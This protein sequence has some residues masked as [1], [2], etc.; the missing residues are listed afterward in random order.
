MKTKDLKTVDSIRFP[1]PVPRDV[2]V[3]PECG[4]ELEVECDCWDT[5]TGK[6]LEECI[7]PTCSNEIMEHRCW[8][9]EW[10][11]ARM[12]V[13]RWLQATYRIR[14]DSGVEDTS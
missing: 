9:G 14:E 1:M 11:P 7:Y 8:Q 4:G 12:R 3:C 2:A 6:P 5:D 13:I 10:M